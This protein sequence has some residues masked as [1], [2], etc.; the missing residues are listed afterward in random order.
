LLTNTPIHTNATSRGY[1]ALAIG[2]YLALSIAII[3]YESRPPQDPV[4]SY[5][6]AAINLLRDGRVGELSR[7]LGLLDKVAPL[8]PLS[9]AMWSGVVGTGYYQSLTFDQLIATAR[10]LLLL[11]FFYPWLVARLNYGEGKA[12]STLGLLTCFAF[13]PHLR[14][15]PLDLSL[16]LALATWFVLSRKPRSDSWSAVGASILLGLSIAANLPTG[17]LA[18]FG[19]RCLWNVAA[20]DRPA[21]GRFLLRAALVETLFVG[22]GLFLLAG[23]SFQPVPIFPVRVTGSGLSFWTLR[24]GI[25]FLGP[26]ISLYGAYLIL[27]TY[28]PI[29]SPSLL[30]SFDRIARWSVPLLIGFVITSP[31]MYWVPF[32]VLF[33]AVTLVWLEPD[34][35]RSPIWVL[36]LVFGVMLP[37]LFPEVRD[38]LIALQAPPTQ[39]GRA[40]R[41]RVLSYLSPHSTLAVSPDQFFTFLNSSN[42][43]ILYY[44]CPW[45][46]RF[47]YVYV[48]SRSELRQR[49]D[50]EDCARDQQC[51][52]RIEDFRDTRA[53]I[54]LG[55]ITPLQVIGNGGQLFKNTQCPNAIYASNQR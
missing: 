37:S 39:S 24:R 48:S 50:T 52:S 30:A 18:L 51:F 15:Q 12:I 3:G 14:D 28:H 27:R 26:L 45:N 22:L 35:H 23:P 43:S 21:V 17:L 11:A 54:F 44:T 55:H 20:Y 4:Y 9:F 31:T 32:S 2:L 33:L 16:T 46:R 7:P 34:S 49:R 29:R 53:F 40:V 13:L 38:L 42:V 19:A 1:F 10:V 41:D 6:E 47:D 8:Y 25:T 36:P 5:K